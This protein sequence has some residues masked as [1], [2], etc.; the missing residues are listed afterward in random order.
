MG[1]VRKGAVM[2]KRTNAFNAVSKEGMKHESRSRNRLCPFAPASIAVP[3]QADEKPGAATR[4]T[5]TR[6]RGSLFFCAP[7]WQF[8]YFTTLQNQA[9]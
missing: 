3:E 7:I 6:Q 9:S 1:I 5:G 8:N 4:Y 2:K